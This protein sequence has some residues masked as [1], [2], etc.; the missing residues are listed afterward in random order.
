MVRKRSKLEI[1]VEI[2]RTTLSGTNKTRIVY[3]TN[4]NFKVAEKYLTQ[5]EELGLLK[6]EDIDGKKVY[7]TTEAGEKFLEKFEKL[8]KI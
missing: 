6:I 2:L 1:I 7:K 3:Q 8:R 4:L 5:L